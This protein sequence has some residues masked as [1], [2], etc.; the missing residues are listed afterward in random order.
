MQNWAQMQR[1]RD[2]Q[3]GLGDSLIERAS[4]AGADQQGPVLKNKNRKQESNI[5]SGMTCQRNG[6]VK[7]LRLMRK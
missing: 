7:D 4:Q 5:T 3:D 6:L 1:Q 2:R